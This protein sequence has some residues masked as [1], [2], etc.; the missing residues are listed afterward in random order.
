MNDHVRV[1]R[2]RTRKPLLAALLAV[3]LLLPGAVPA[4]QAASL[5]GMI[6][7]GGYEMGAFILA[8]GSLA[9][10][11]EPGAQAPLSAQ[12]PPGRVSELPG[13]SV[14]VDDAWGWSGQVRT[15]PATGEVMRQLNWVLAEHGNTTDS[16]KAV[17]VQIALWELRREPGNAAW[18]DGKYA[19]FNR[20][21]GAA[22]V[23]AGKR[24]AAEAKTAAVGPG[25]VRPD[26]PLEL[27]QDTED[28]AESGAVSY[29]RGTTELKIAGGRFADGST[30]LKL[31]GSTAGSV[32]WSAT[33]HEPA[34]ARFNDVT[35]SGTWA[36]AERYWPAE[37]I[38][39]PS[40]RAVE[41]RLGS[42][43]KPVVGQ[44]TGAL[45]PVSATFDSRFAPAV[46]TQVPEELVPRTTGLFRDRV[47][48]SEADG[49]WPE[50][51]DGGEMLPLLAEGTL[52]G[53]FVSP[54]QE[55]PDPPVDAPVAARASVEITEGPGTYDVETSLAGASSGYYYWLWMIREE[56]QSEEIRAAEILQPG[57]V[58]AD[59]FGVL[60]ERQIVPTEL[61][62]QTRLAEHTITPSART[63]QDS[64]RAT[65]V[66]G[67]WLQDESGARLQANVRLTFYQLNERPERQAL[68][69]PAARE[70]GHVLVPMTEV[71]R[72]TEAPPFTIPAD[73]RGWV[74]VQ[75]CL[76]AAD[77]TAEIV[78][79]I[80]EWCDD[81]GVPDETAQ[82]V[83]PLAET[84][85]PAPRPEA[86][87]TLFPIS[88]EVALGAAL[89][90]MGGL[91]LGIALLRRRARLM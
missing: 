31:D 42:G 22:F 23:T 65:L 89:L 13:Y 54:Q 57:A 2:N 66:G 83:E 10:C 49:R 90:G 79:K 62:W 85:G 43:V 64:V 91:S 50:R 36:L 82:I 60:A 81:F 28:G 38:V 72:W 16:E 53:P 35:I 74:T 59:R 84:G 76:I 6:A 32:R 37:L 68:P 21:G 26:A 86:L 52:Y 41:Q 19:H 11:L 4:A 55:A 51:L 27:T 24:L 67:E 77:Q 39:H 14:Y 17:A 34:W 58:H 87:G 46:T 56:G 29:P 30:Q 70:L 69:S 71:D 7:I 3:P 48:V 80:T 61:R 40:S 18:I 9:Y 33:P 47:T 75:A 15:S 73:E 45:G 63:L 88:P 8:D 78:G 44:N 12:L 25:N 5:D 20:N 1:R